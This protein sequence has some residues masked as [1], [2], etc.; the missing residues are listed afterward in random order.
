M[1]SLPLADVIASQAMPALYPR[2]SCTFQP[3][4]PLKA[5]YGAGHSLSPREAA[6]RLPEP[7]AQLSRAN[8]RKRSYAGSTSG[9]CRKASFDSTN[10]GGET[11]GVAQWPQ[12]GKAQ[13]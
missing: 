6:E 10:T 13:A 2:H 4:G 12:D 1:P 3:T 8:S 9:S 11:L 5:E 7:K